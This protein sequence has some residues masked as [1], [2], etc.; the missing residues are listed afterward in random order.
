MAY[1]PGLAA[2]LA[3]F[4]FVMSGQTS[5]LF[6]GLGVL[7]VLLT[8]WL[9]LKLGI[10]DRNASPYHRAPQIFVWLVWLLGE[11]VKANLVVA[12]RIMGPLTSLDPAVVKVNGGCK[13]DLGKTLFANSITLT[14]GTV[15]VEVDNG[16]MLLHALQRDNALPESFEPMARKAAMAAGD[17]D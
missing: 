7:S 16:V 15:T 4:W 3:V 8:L 9:S 11:I 10:V 1:I 17:G 12:R 14:P 13:S 2:A 6:L 5:P